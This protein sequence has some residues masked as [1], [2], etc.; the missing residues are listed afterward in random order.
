MLGNGTSCFETRAVRNGTEKQTKKKT[1]R[2]DMGSV[3]SSLIL[4]SRHASVKK[5][6]MRRAKGSFDASDLI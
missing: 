3:K 4:P 6:D 5:K 2:R 1:K